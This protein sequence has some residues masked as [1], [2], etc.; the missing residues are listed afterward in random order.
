[1]ASLLE[2]LDATLVLPTLNPLCDNVLEA[3]VLETE[4]P[5]P[6]FFTTLLVVVSTDLYVISWHH[7]TLD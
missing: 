4:R 6:V 1:V 5:I 2:I 7:I 3:I